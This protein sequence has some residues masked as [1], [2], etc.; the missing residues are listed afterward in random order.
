[1]GRTK[2]IAA[3]PDIG[4]T[5]TASTGCIATVV[6]PRHAASAEPA[7]ISHALA[8]TVAI[9]ALGIVRCTPSAPMNP[10]TSPVPG[11]PDPDEP[12]EPPNP[13]DP[14][15]EIPEPR[16]PA[17]PIHDPRIPLPHEPARGV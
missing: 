17:D 4:A 12:A 11:E 7:A 2:T 15:P 10:P 14:D 5:C 6:V 8:P 3:S 13:G 1:G 9:V 16:S